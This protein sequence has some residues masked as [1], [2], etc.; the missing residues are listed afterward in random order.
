M[1][2]KSGEDVLELTPDE[3]LAYHSALINESKQMQDYIDAVF[4]N[5]DKLEKEYCEGRVKYLEKA[6]EITN[7]I[8]MAI[9][10]D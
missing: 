5:D 2:I 10:N 4:K 8:I 9:K 6:M 1:E 3:L 7:K